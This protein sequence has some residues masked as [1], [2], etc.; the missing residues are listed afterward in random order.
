MMNGI[1]AFFTYRVVVTYVWFYI[2]FQGKKG[3]HDER[4]IP[5]TENFLITSTLQIFTFNVVLLL[6]VAIG[7]LNQNLCVPIFEQRTVIAF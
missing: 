6:C 4:E 3:L 1:M 7:V 5:Y 2:R